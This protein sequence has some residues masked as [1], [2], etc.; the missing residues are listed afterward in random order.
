MFHGR[1][2]KDNE[3]NWVYVYTE[4]VDTEQL[5]LQKEEVEEVRWM[6]YEE[7]HRQ[8]LAGTLSNCIYED[9]FRMVGEYL[10]ELA[11]R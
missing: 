5:I 1:M 7:C 8:I 10:K 4:A 9:E 11:A 2:F 6:D 3:L